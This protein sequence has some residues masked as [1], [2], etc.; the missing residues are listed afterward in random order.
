MVSLSNNLWINI[1]SCL[2]VTTIYDINRNVKTSY[3]SVMGTL[4]CGKTTVAKLIAKEL[5]FQILE[6]NF[7]ENKFL[8]RFYQDM[9]KWA[10]HSQTFFL[11]EKTN[12]MF[13]AKK[14]LEKQSVIQDVPIQQDVFSYAKAQY[15]LGNMESAEWRLYT[16]IYWSFEPHFPKP[17]LIVYLETSTDLLLK[18]IKSRGRK[19]EQ[20]IKPGYLDLLAKLNKE[21]ITQHNK[22]DVIKINMDSHDVVRSLSARESVIEYIRE[23]I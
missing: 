22:T 5:G 2:H 13:E 21:W 10:F 15:R 3:I 6:E 9:K 8:S 7:G 12:Q 18:R 23:Y 1:F 11:M 20:S 14:L 4:G 17:D 16:K 19:Y